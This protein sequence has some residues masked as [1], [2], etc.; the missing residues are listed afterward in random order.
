MQT[1]QHWFDSYKNYYFYIFWGGGGSN[2]ESILASLEYSKY[3]DKIEKGAIAFSLPISCKTTIE[4]SVNARF[5]MNPTWDL[6]GGGEEFSGFG[7]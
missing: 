7:G 3:F 1:T 2:Q 5:Q 4:Y 6:F